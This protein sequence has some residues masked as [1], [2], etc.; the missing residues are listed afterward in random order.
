MYLIQL[1]LSKLVKEIQLVINRM[2]TT[3]LAN[4]QNMELHLLELQR[5]MRSLMNN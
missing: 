2:M 4:L 3:I 1:Q 5:K